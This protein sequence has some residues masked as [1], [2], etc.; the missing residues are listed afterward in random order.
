MPVY[1]PW[2][3]SFEDDTPSLGRVCGRFSITGDLDF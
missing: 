1:G 2:N 3:L